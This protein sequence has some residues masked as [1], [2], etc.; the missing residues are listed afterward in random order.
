MAKRKQ[1]FV[2]CVK[3]GTYKASLEP[4]KVYRV[5]EDLAAEAKSLLRV[6][7]ESGEDYLFPGDPVR[8]HRSA[9]Q[10]SSDLRRRRI[11]RQVAFVPRAWEAVQQADAADEAGAS[12]GASQ[13]IRSVRRTVGVPDRQ[14]EPG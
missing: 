14:E 3:A 13:L 10:G 9:R 1:R 11:G 12:D 8:A 7:D 6:V 5:I 2:L 4:R